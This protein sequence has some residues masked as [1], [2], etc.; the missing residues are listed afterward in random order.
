MTVL[1]QRPAHIPRS[2]ACYALG[3]SRTGTYPRAR[4]YQPHTKPQPQPRALSAEEREH[5]KSVMNSEAN[6]DRSVRVV[7]ALSLNAGR[8][9]P[10]VSSIYRILRSERQVRE[11]RAQRPPQRHA[12]PRLLASRPNQIWSW[13]ISKLPTRTPRVYL[14]LYQ[15]LDLKSRFPVAWMISRKENAALAMHLFRKALERYDI[16]PD[17]LTV[18]QDRGAPMIADSYR[19]FL[20][21]YG[22]RRSY[23]RPRVSNDNAYSESFFK[24]VKYAPGYPR[25]FD[26]SGHARTWMGTFIGDY[27]ERPH[28]GLAFYAPSDVFCDRVDEVHARRQQ[29]LDEYYSNHPERFP[30][31]RPIA[32][33]PPEIVTI[34]PEDGVTETAAEVL[35]RGRP[36][37]LSSP[38]EVAT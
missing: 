3:L 14:N 38:E 34:N 29:A 8:P 11:R 30:R 35:R 10:S 6:Q 31:G 26:G 28:E 5:V 16:Q 33:Y 17:Q 37:I 20:D 36:G 32:A 1:G 24:T 15:I 21:R 18:H 22:V 27:K 2:A 4:R 25:R 9:L 13:D 23:S 7:H 12:I 19:E